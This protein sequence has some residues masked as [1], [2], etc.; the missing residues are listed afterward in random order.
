M[1]GHFWF[2]PSPGLHG[3]AMFADPP[4]RFRGGGEV[5]PSLR[6]GRLK[7][8]FS[9]LWPRDHT[10]RGL[11]WIIVGMGKDQILGNIL[12]GLQAGQQADL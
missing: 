10:F 12:H 8:E 9:Y 11:V 1:G 3:Y 2:V 6:Y 7:N 5:S 4:H